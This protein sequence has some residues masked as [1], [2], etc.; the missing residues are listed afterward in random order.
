M[1]GVFVGGWM[2]GVVCGG[3]VVGVIGYV[4]VWFF[5]WEGRRGGVWIVWVEVVGAA[6]F[7]LGH[8][9]ALSLLPSPQPVHYAL[10]FVFNALIGLIYGWLFARHSLVASMLAHAGTHVGAFVVLSVLA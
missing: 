4:V 5:E 1:L 2:G 10:V 6:L 7:A 9:P 8:V 3:G